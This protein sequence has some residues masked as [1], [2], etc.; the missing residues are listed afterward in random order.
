MV[1]NLNLFYVGSTGI[2][3]IIIRSIY[4]IVAMDLLI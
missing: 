2:R 4:N 3:P 1:D